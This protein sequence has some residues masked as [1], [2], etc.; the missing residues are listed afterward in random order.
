[1]QLEVAFEFTSEQII[2]SSI[3]NNIGQ[4]RFCPMRKKCLFLMYVWALNS[5]MFPEFL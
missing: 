2:V 5:N 1:M 4:Q 3:S